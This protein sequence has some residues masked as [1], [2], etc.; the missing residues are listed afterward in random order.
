[1]EGKAWQSSYYLCHPGLWFN[2]IFTLTG[3][4][5]PREHLKIYD[6][7]EV[8]NGVGAALLDS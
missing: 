3:D 5:G 1:M 4:T 6:D 8:G 2:R 7:C